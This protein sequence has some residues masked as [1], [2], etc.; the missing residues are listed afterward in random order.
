MYQNLTEGT[1]MMLGPGRACYRRL[2]LSKGASDDS[3]GAHIGNVVMLAQASAGEILTEMPPRPDVLVDSMV[4][5]FTGPRHD[6][7]STMGSCQKT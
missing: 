5:A 3:Q 1:K 4:I 2:F 6:L 7:H